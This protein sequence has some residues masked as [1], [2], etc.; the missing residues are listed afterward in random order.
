[1]KTASVAMTF[2]YVKCRRSQSITSP[3]IRALPVAG[4]PDNRRSLAPRLRSASGTSRP[5]RRRSG[6][7]SPARPSPNPYA[8]DL[9]P[10]RLE[11]VAGFRG[12][13]GPEPVSEESAA[14]PEA[15]FHVPRSVDGGRDRAEGLPAA[16]QHHLEL[17]EL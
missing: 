1:M 17:D 6:R 11:R 8:D 5:R 14:A 12:K 10:S 3:P 4:T 13:A 2:A 15:V 9:G 7:F 16:R